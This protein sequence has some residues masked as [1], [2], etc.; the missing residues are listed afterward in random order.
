MPTLRG[1]S[2][3]STMT[4]GASGLDNGAAPSYTPPMKK[5]ELVAAE[6]VSRPVYFR[7]RAL[8]DIPEV[9]VRAG[10][11][12][13]LV[14]SEAN[15]SHDG[16]CW[17]RS[18]AVVDG[19]AAVRGD[20]I[21]Y[22][23]SVVT[24]NAVVEG[25]AAVG[26]GGKVSGN[27]VVTDKVAV[28]WGGEVGGNARVGGSAVVSE[29][30]RVGG[31]AVVEGDARIGGVARVEDKAVVRGEARVEGYARVGGDAVVKGDAVLYGHHLVDTGTVSS[32]HDL[33]YIDDGTVAVTV[34]VWTGAARVL[35]LKSGEPSVCHAAQLPGEISKRLALAGIVIKP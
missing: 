24:G 18:E 33:L 34:Q 10:E 16:S 6:G 1:F 35:D 30:A 28:L 3:D 15:L 8:R 31:H 4:A 22:G 26:M 20:A 29:G 11:F 5:Y 25:G 7:I 14:H 13:G 32:R 17:I 21:V 12:G 2:V 23:C 27:A 9:G 19:G